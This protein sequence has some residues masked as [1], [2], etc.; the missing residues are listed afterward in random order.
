[1]S[2]RLAK[3]FC[4]SLYMSCC[5][6]LFVLLEFLVILIVL[7]CVVLSWLSSGFSSVAARVPAACRV[8]GGRWLRIVWLSLVSS[9]PW[10]GT[11]AHAHLIRC[12][13]FHLSWFVDSDCESKTL[14]LAVM[15]DY[16]P[17][18]CL[19]CRSSRFRS[20][21]FVFL[22]FGMI[23]VFFWTT[24]HDRSGDI[25]AQ[26]W[27]RTQSGLPWRHG[28]TMP[29]LQKATRDLTIRKP[30]DTKASRNEFPYKKKSACKILHEIAC[31]MSS[32]WVS[33]CIRCAS[34]K[35]TVILFSPVG[36]RISR[37]HHAVSSPRL[38]F[39]LSQ[40]EHPPH[41][42]CLP[43]V[44]LVQSH[45]TPRPRTECEQSVNLL[46]HASFFSL[47]DGMKR[48]ARALG[49]LTNKIVCCPPLRMCWTTTSLLLL[50]PDPIIPLPS[51]P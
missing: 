31:Q 7:H 13:Q 30:L 25:T 40:P 15:W 26:C 18:S 10:C 19:Q 32:L 23:F 5:C 3:V 42:F 1:M 22:R 29:S 20:I 24:M 47:L 35:R 44:D 27:R 43:S 38:I 36:H 46:H 9:C 34:K 4:F 49:L 6:V 37:R 16:L 48:Y 51:A 12:C 17:C 21:L 11:A 14:L 50:V 28:S 45:S 8:V 39:L 41:H 33:T 2:A